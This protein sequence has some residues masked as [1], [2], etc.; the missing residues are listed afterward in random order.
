MLA[1]ALAERWLKPEAQHTQILNFLESL[2]QT[3]LYNPFV[4]ACFRCQAMSTCDGLKR[5]LSALRKPFI[6]PG[7]RTKV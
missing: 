2:I 1:V 5:I 4:H 6:A 3:P 7:R